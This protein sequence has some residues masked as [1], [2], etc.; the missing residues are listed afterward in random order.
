MTSQELKTLFNRLGLKVPEA[1]CRDIA[2]AIKYI[3]EMKDS[4]RKISSRTTESAHTIPF[5]EVK[6]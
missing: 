2:S 4:V 1:E 5:P 3:D 6:R